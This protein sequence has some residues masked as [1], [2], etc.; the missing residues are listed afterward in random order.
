M[1]P[2]SR[3]RLEALGVV[4]RVYG[5]HASMTERGLRVVNPA[6]AGCCAAHPSDVISVRAREEDGGRPWFFTSWR[7]PLAEAERVVDAVMAIR[8][9]LDGAPGA[10]L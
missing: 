10:A 1:T 5:L 6:V 3:A 7:H 2:E 8:E 4:L 9:L